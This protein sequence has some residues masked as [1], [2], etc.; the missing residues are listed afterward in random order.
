FTGSLITLPPR[1]G[2]GIPTVT[3]SQLQPF[4]TS[5]VPATISAAVRDGPESK[6][7]RVFAREVKAFTCEPPTSTARTTRLAMTSRSGRLRL[8]F[9]APCLLEE[10]GVES[11]APVSWLC[12]SDRDLHLELVVGELLDAVSA[13]DQRPSGALVA[14]W[15]QLALPVAGSCRLGR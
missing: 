5:K 2:D 4:A 3:A 10:E 8:P 12:R 13:V 9:P 14:L 11:R 1:T 6:R 7:R 15:C